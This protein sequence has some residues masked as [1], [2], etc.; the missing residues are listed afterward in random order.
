MICYFVYFILYNNLF[1]CLLSKCILFIFY[2]FFV[3]DIDFRKI[4]NSFWFEKL[5]CCML[6]VR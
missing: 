6:G 4:V 5:V 2:L 3:V 1:K